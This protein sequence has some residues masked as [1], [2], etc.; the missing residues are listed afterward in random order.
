LQKIIQTFGLRK[1]LLTITQNGGHN[2]SEEKELK[3]KLLKL[4]DEYE[5]S[6]ASGTHR[7]PDVIADDAFSSYQ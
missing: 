3:E 4:D 6:I 1:N 2:M 7:E 5:C